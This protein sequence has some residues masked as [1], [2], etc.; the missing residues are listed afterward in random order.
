MSNILVSGA[1]R[2]GSS[3]IA[4]SL[5]HLF[6]SHRSYLH[7]AGEGYAQ[8]S[9][10]L[11]PHVVSVMFDRMQGMIY[12]SHATG[13]KYNAGIIKA[14]KPFTIVCMR[15]LL[16]SLHSLRRYEDFLVNDGRK[17]DKYFNQDWPSYTDYQ[18]WFWIAYNAIPWYYQFY[19]SWMKTDCPHHLVWYEEH[20]KDQVA[21][22]QKIMDFLGVNTTDEDIA[23]HFLP[24]HKNSNYTKSRETF[25]IPRFVKKIAMSQ[26]NAWGPTWG[27]KIVEDL[28]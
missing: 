6:G 28:L 25:K 13:S 2:S 7:K 16:P 18:K 12:L 14:F 19:V 26:A 8:D 15:K 11:D 3:H 20:H 5:A 23:N 24:I 17:D 21:S 27:P 10:R 4:E 1:Y 22:A 9:Q